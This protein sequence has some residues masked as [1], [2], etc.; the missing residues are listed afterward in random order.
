MDGRT[1]ALRG[2]GCQS[3]RVESR[4][5]TLRPETNTDG[6]VLADFTDGAS[7]GEEFLRG[8]EDAGLIEEVLREQGCPLLP[9]STEDCLV[10]E[11]V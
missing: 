5:A 8:D 4:N 3:H 7:Q 10:R 2:E 1:K 11:S 9:T 6:S